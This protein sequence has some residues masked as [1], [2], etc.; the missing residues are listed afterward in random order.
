MTLFTLNDLDFDLLKIKCKIILNDMYVFAS[1][2]G[3]VSALK[4]RYLWSLEALDPLGAGVTGSWEPPVVG[5]V[6][7]THILWKSLNC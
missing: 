3:W 1:V 4:G 6:S 5:T 7:R 2:L